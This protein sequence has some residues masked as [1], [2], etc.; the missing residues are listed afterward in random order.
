MLYYS[1]YLFVC[2]KYFI[3]FLERLQG[4]VTNLVTV[5]SRSVDLKLWPA[6]VSVGGLVRTLIAGPYAQSCVSVSLAG[7]RNL[8]F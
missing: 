7:P 3:P 1:L 2:L 8:N 4:S 6:S 5:K